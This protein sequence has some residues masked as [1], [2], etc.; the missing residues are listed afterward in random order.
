MGDFSA[1]WLAAREDADRRSRSRGLAEK[2]LAASTQGDPAAPTLIDLGCGSGNNAAY[3]GSQCA[4]P[5]EWHLIDADAAL[6]QMAAGRL[7]PAR[8]RT[9]VADIADP[10]VLGP[11]IEGAAGLACS[12]LLDLVSAGWLEGFARTLAVSRVPV[13]AALTYSGGMTFDPAHPDDAL[14]VAA[15][16]RH[17]S[18][19]KGLGS[20][21]GPSAGPRFKREL[22][23][24]GY[25]TFTADTAWSLTPG[26]GS[27]IAQLVTGIREA[28]G[29]VSSGGDA[30]AVEA[31]YRTRM[32]QT[33]ALRATVSHVDVMGLPANASKD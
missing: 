31:W 19:D 14:V 33:V 13:L 22:E 3:L 20:A 32:E 2:F 30:A 28:A 9:T 6:L 1:E 18:S 29:E 27:M 11:A 15:F 16:N 8:V 7:A 25:E 23:R 21:L 17:Q 4:A 24:S 5:V 12:A 10:A 26:D